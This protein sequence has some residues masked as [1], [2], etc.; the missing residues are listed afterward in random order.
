MFR[1]LYARLAAVLVVVF[2]TIGVSYALITTATIKSYLQELS[3]HFN[4]DLAKR[5]V[6]DRILVIDGKINHKALKG[7]FMS[8]MEINPSIE[9]YLLNKQGEILSFSAEPGRVKRKQVDLGPIHS[10][11]RGEGF[12]L[13]GD[14]PRSHD[15][16]KAFSVTPVPSAE[17][18]EGYLYVVLQGEQYETAERLIQES[19]VFRLSAWAITGSLGFGLIVAL[20]LFHLLTRRMQHLSDVMAQFQTSEFTQH[21][22]YKGDVNNKQ[23]E[24][25]RLGAN[26]D[27]MAQRMIHLLSELKDQDQLRRELV[28]QISH[29]LR[30]P[31]AALHGYLETLKM[32]RNQL[33]EKHQQEFLEIALRQSNH[34]KRM[35]EELFEL[36][37]LEARDAELIIEPCYIAELLQDILQKFKLRA[38][39]SAVVLQMLLPDSN[40]VLDVDIGLIERALDNLISNAIDHT[41]VGGNVTMELEVKTDAVIICVSDSGSGIAEVDLPHLFDPFFRG[42]QQGKDKR[43]AGLGLAITKRICDL[44]QARLWV[45]S[46]EAGGAKF[47]LSLPKTKSSTTSC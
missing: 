12:P 39:F 2:I 41:P 37:H 28:A 6:A 11:L 13:L 45:E 18:P 3:Q 33:D 42:Q 21:I 31:L 8:Y 38:E 17:N 16:Q 4:R 26:F 35:T 10:F 47:C 25:E 24:I 19:Y 32:K 9:I 43:H 22:P 7:T 36:A 15:R 30:T 46:N 27:D 1:T 5:I 40:P 23:D 34:L 44:Q 29:D 14:D 20:L